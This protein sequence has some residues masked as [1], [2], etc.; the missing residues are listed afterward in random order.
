MGAGE[1]ASAQNDRVTGGNRG[2][3]RIAEDVPFLVGFS[4]QVIGA[5]GV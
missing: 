5:A 1:Q 4:G 2:K 3:T